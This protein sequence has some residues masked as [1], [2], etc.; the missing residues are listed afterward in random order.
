MSGI[1][2]AGAY[3]ED[4]RTAGLLMIS[5]L[6]AHSEGPPTVTISIDSMR[7][8]D[9]AARRLEAALHQTSLLK[10]V[11]PSDVESHR[12]R[13]IRDM[14]QGRLR[15]PVFTY[16]EADTA[17]FRPLQEITEEC[18]SRGDPLSQLVAEEALRH[19]NRFQACILHDANRI[20]QATSEENGVPD[21]ALLTEA[22]KLLSTGQARHRPEQKRELTAEYVLSAVEQTL[23]AEGLTEWKARI[24]S[25]M[26]ARMSVTSG[27][28]SVNIRADLRLAEDELVALITHEVGTHVFRWVNACRVARVLSVRLSGATGTEEG[29][30]VWNE[31]RAVAGNTLDP[32]FALRVVAVDAALRGSF[33]DVVHAL[34]PYTSVGDAF[35]VA[36]RVKRG[37]VDTAEP[38]GFIKDHVYMAGYRMVRE[39]LDQNPDEHDL[40]MATKWP[41]HRLAV[42]RDADVVS[43]I[44]DDIRRPDRHFV[45]RTQAV[46]RELRAS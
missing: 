14:R 36:T 25:K 12:E 3:G 19:L 34:L 4:G 27:N 44:G 18:V 2:S 40:L 1:A 38:G 8:A 30:A 43:A 39:H 20:T 13:F 5:H 22:V 35:D 16:P 10:A 23:R 28:R 7:G 21:A 41:L 11:L 31:Q 24:N 17:R 6:D 15:S 42:L 29:L 37:L 26:A 46:V 33:V 45:E 9:S 32:R